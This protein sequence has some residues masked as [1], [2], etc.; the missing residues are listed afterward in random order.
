MSF[1]RNKKVLITGH[2]GFLGSWLT[3]TLIERKANIVGLDQAI[4]RPVSVLNGFRDRLTAI[5]GDVSDYEL[6][7][8]IIKQHKPQV[9]FHLAAQATVESSLKN[10]RRALKT[11]IEGAWN[12]L[13]AC[14]A[15]RSV[16]AVVFSSS[17]KAY[18]SQKKLPYTEDMPLQGK[19]PYDVSKS[20]ADLIC[21]TY[22][23]TFQVPV[24]ITRCGNIYGPGD[25]HDSRI[26]PD[27]V[28]SVL[29]GKRL[30]IRSNGRYTRDYIY[31]EDI[32]RG[33]IVLA[34]KIQSLKLL[35]QAFNFSNEKPLSVLSLFSEIVSSA[36]KITKLK[37]IEPKI[38]NR[39][40]FEI[41]HQYLSSR[42]ANRVLG[43]KAHYD[44]KQGL[45]K[46]IRWYQLHG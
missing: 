4:G 18:G 25:F 10:P 28:K 40:Q 14:R 2:E 16:K 26:V 36:K 32:V 7:H 19:H 5:K 6:V 31:V 44:L 42:K 8:R 38:L 29:K 39:A 21:Q 23:H 45:D 33:Y 17:D 37:K 1:W 24:C 22:A 3:K 41:Q 15:Q 13:E 27:A 9:I 12:I 35:G 34:E 43:W 46:T 30:I 20:C 11:N